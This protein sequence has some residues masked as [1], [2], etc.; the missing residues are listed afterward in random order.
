MADLQ[1]DV[2]P[3][4]RARLRELR[5]REAMLERLLAERGVDPARIGPTVPS[6]TAVD[7]ATKPGELLERLIRSLRSPERSFGRRRPASRHPG[8]DR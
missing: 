6:G 7:P 1:R 4:L 2:A 3:V 8:T 5:A